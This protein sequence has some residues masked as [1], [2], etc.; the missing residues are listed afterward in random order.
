M[1]GECESQECNP[2]T[3]RD[4]RLLD[5]VIEKHRD[6]DQH[7]TKHR[8]SR[9]EGIVAHLFKGDTYAEIMAQIDAIGILGYRF[10]YLYE[11]RAG[12][13]LKI[14]QRESDHGG[15]PPPLIHPEE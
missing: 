7:K 11:K 3:A 9:N 14:R 4:E 8:D 13:L 10:A 2:F 1:C 6:R 12:K 15:E 5:R